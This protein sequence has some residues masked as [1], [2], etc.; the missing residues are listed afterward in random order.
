VQFC[1][2]REC[3]LIRYAFGRAHLDPGTALLRLRQMRAR[4]LTFLTFLGGVAT[5]ALAIAIACALVS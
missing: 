5:V 2:R 1:A 3:A 4:H